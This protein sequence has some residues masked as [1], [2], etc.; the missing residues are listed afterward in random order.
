LPTDFDVPITLVGNPKVIVWVVELNV[1]K[2]VGLPLVP[3]P[4]IY[5]LVNV[6][7]TDVITY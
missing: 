3:P 6:L 5:L 7:V 2:A 1:P 4:G